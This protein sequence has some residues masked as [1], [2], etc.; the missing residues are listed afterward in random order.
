MKTCQVLPRHSLF[1]LRKEPFTTRTRLLHLTDMSLMSK[2]YEL[3]M[4]S[5]L[6][7]S[8]RTLSKAFFPSTIELVSI[9]P[10]WVR[11]EIFTKEIVI[12][13]FIV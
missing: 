11:K 1:R 9:F 8:A 6:A 13:R 5:V 10:F 12:A 2:S 7:I 3:M 4:A